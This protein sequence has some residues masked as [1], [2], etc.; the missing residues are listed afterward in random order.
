MQ[1][2]LLSVTSYNAVQIQSIHGLHYLEQ[3]SS[4]V[5]CRH[6]LSRLRLSSFDSHR[7]PDEIPAQS[8]VLHNHEELCQETD[9]LMC[10]LS[11]LLGPSD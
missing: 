3:S 7:S 11:T 9:L 5:S 10:P 6:E 4:E 8:T 1:Q 2:L